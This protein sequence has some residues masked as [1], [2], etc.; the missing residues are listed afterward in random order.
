MPGVRSPAV[1]TF[2][3]DNYDPDSGGFHPVEIRID[4]GGKIEY[5]TDFSYVGNG[6]F[7]ELVKEIDFDFSL[8]LFQHFG[9][10]HSIGHGLE[11]YRL[12]ERNFVAYYQMGVYSVRVDAL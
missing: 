5:I 8:R 3:D 7:A 12:W 1:L 4:P 11:L 2:K 9:R 10:E 6:P